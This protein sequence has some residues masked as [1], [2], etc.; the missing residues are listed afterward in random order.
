MKMLSNTNPWV[1]PLVLGFQLD[2]LPLI[3]TLQTWQFSQFLLCHCP[4]MQYIFHQFC[5]WR[6]YRRQCQKPHSGQDKLYP[7]LSTHPPSQSFHHRCLPDGSGMISNGFVNLTNPCWLLAITLSLT[8]FETV[9]RSIC[10]ITFL[11]IKMMVTRLKF[12]D[13]LSWK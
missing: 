2:N 9:F 12:S 1:I 3:T 5:L 7:L 13:L 10:S 4:F 8:F 6:C 11:T